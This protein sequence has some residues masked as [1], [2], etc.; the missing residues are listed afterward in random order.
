[1]FW[2]IHDG[3]PEAKRHLFKYKGTKNPTDYWAIPH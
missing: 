1:M 3:Y 2:L